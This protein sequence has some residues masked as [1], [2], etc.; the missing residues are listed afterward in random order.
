MK[1]ICEEFRV[2]LRTTLDNNKSAD[3]SFKKKFEV[4]LDFILIARQV[5]SFVILL[6]EKVGFLS[7]VIKYI[8]SHKFSFRRVSLFREVLKSLGVVLGQR[9]GAV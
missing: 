2:Y 7:E 9:G 4:Q 8:K 3:P 5:H 1:Q 6:Y